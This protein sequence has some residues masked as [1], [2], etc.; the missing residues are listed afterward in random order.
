MKILFFGRG[1]IGTQYAWALE[2]AGHAVEFYVRGGRKAQY[3]S[4]V[5]LEI[6]DARRS[7]N[8]RLIKERWPVAI[9]EDIKSNH[10][11][12]LIFVS[13]NPEQV[14]SAARYLAPRAGNATVLFIGNFWQDIRKSVRPIPFSQ[15][16][17][18]F[19]GCGGGFEGN[20][21][22]GGLY[23]TI[24][25][26]TFESEPAQR[27]S[28]LHRLFAG[29]GFKAAVQ[30]DFQSWLRNHFASNAAMEAEAIK[31][32]SFKEAVSSRE[33]LAGIARNMRE[34]IPVIRATGSKPNALARVMSCLPPRAVGFLMGKVF[35]PKGMPY[36][37]VAHNH[38]KAGPAVQE[39]ISE[40]RKHGIN[41][42]RLCAAENLIAK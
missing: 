23:K 27:D 38:Y 4:H 21:L 36:A 22:Y 33:S 19:P 11:Y 24:Y 15:V 7:N 25:F 29:A 13:V 41:V 9:H 32:G 1:A 39:I 12:D 28:E 18:G 34:I 2:N 16:V 35:S 3:G 17:W 40:A 8:G 26:G 30:K 10:G 37:L 5:D 42:P 14:P 31:S 6:F 20:T